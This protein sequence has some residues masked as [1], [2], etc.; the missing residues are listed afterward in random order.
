MESMGFLTSQPIPLDKTGELLGG[1][2]R[3]ACALALEIPNVGV[4]WHGH[5][6]WA[7][8]WDRKWFWDARMAPEDYLR[9]EADWELMKK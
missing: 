8:S 9:L 6:V 4:E 7:P 1:A 5:R 2:H 3:L